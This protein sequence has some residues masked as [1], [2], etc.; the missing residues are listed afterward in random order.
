M[1]EQYGKKGNNIFISYFL[2]FTKYAESTLIGDDVA[3]VKLR[4]LES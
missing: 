1:Y 2:Y 4:H 3:F